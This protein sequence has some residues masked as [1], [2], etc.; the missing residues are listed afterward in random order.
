MTAAARAE[1]G[2]APLP[3]ES[4]LD[5][6]KLTARGQS[7]EATVP[8]TVDLADRARL[9]LNNL[10]HNVDPND[11]YYVYQVINFGSKS[12]GPDPRSRTFDL[13]GK[14]LRALPWMRTMCGSD[15]FVDEEYGMLKAM[16]S[17]VGED[18]L[19]YYPVEGYRVKNTSYPAVN[20]LLALACENHYVLDDNPQWLDWIQLLANGL[21]KLAIHVEDRAYYPPECTVTP[22][23]KWVWNTRGKAILP[24]DPPQEPYLDQQGL[25][26]TVKWEQAYPMRALVRA[27]KYK[28]DRE[29]LDLLHSLIRFDLKPGMWE[30]TTLDGYKGNQ[31]GVF[32]GHFHG[33]TAALLSLFDVA[34]ATRDPWLKQFVREAYD[35]AIRN[36]A[37]R[38]GWYPGWIMPAK[39]ERDPSLSGVTEG[40]GL[41]EMIELGVRLTD[42]GLG[43]YWDDV[44]AIA[45]NQLAEQQ[46]CNLDVMR[47]MAQG[48]P[49]E[50]RLTEFVGGFGMGSPT[51]I[52]PEMYG[53]CSVN[54]S[55]GLYYAWEGITR[56][57]DGL[58]TVNLFLN[59]AS[60]W[61]DVDSY[62]PYEGKVELHNK[63]ARTA[64]VR[65]PTWVD[66]D[67]TRSYVDGVPVRRPR[68][69]RY[70]VFDG[71]RKGSVVRLEF[72]NP[73]IT[74]DHTING[75]LYHITFRG[76]TVLDLQPRP[77]PQLVTWFRGSKTIPLYQRAQ[78]R[79]DKAPMR[80][81]QRFATERVLP[82]Q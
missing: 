60:A 45:R 40:D 72:P 16:M 59:R 65:I 79:S 78:Y 71:L 43:D 5:K 18:G 38:M 27:Y 76:S 58:T 82:L 61:M 74:E 12:A 13:T 23:G 24:Y 51:A 6:S 69:G 42:A 2:G 47:Q 53:C 33:N 19:L 52:K 20:A 68:S 67:S 32:A 34:Q 80:R 28:C 50:K 36:G 35:N 75:H 3:I 4:L 44:D 64:L 15:A 39:Y 21:K 31:H 37:A 22:E 10:T 49:I 81:V 9:S 56:F 8:D 62:L 26:G 57:S 77:D 55:M 48:A 41:G 54:G 66:I 46:F 17:N 14:N 63:Q 25:E 29:A 7:Y 30:N 1:G 70:L 73:E 11:W